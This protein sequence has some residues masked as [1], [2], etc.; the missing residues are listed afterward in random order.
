MKQ[1]DQLSSCHRLRTS[2]EGPLLERGLEPDFPAAALAQLPPWT[3][4]GRPRAPNR[5]E[6]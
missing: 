6:T 5:I 1:D 4:A 3:R 2:E